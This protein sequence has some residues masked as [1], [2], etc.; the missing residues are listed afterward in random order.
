MAASV[1]LTQRELLSLSPEVHSQVCEATSAK[2]KEPVKEIHTLAKDN[3]L[4]FTLDDLSSENNPTNLIFTNVIHQSDS[5]LPGSLIVP[6]PYETY[7]KLLPDGTIP[8][9]LVVAKESSALQS[10][11][12]LVNNQQLIEAIIDLGSQIIAMSKDVCMDL[13]LI[14]DPSIIL[15]MQSANGEVNKSLRLAC[16]MMLYVQIHIIHS[17]AYDNSVDHSIYSLKASLE[18][19]RTRSPSGNI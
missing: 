13:M 12:L 9:T 18:T 7:L 4:P 3:N 14:Y 6:D 15:N 19:L 8:K 17:P 10:I 11:F 2:H 1:I 5:P 16:N